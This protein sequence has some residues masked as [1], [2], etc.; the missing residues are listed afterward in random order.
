MKKL[1]FALILIT[2]F[3][4]AGSTL[5]AQHNLVGKWMAIDK[6][7]TVY[8]VFDEEGYVTLIEDGEVIGGKD[9]TVEGLP[10]SFTYTTN[11]QVKPHHIDMHLK[12]METQMGMM[13]G[14][15]EFV[16][17]NTIKLY[18]NSDDILEGTATPEQISAAR[19]KTYVTDDGPVIFK[20]VKM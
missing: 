4:G 18:M 10:A 15:F 5:S 16:D 7:D 1:L 11:T 19:P 12:A 9:F 14:I 8:V 3:M 13:P 2:A 20:R 17:A 6:T